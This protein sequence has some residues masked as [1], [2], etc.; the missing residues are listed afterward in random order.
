VRLGET[1]AQDMVAERI[2]PDMRMAAVGSPTYFSLRKPPRSPQDLA[3]HNCVNLR[4]PT[5]GGL[6]AWEFEKS[7][8]ALNVRVEGHW[9]STTSRLRWRRLA[10]A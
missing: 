2:G 4:F 6:Y 9:W 8:R 1:I 7:G 5:R 10:T 3:A